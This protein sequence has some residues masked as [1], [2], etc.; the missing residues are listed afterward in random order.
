MATKS[1]GRVSIRVLPDSTKFRSDLR[2]TLDRIEKFMTVKIKVIP[3]L[4]KDQLLKIKQEIEKLKIKITPTIDLKV[5]AEDIARIK[6]QIE[7]MKP[8][9]TISL[10]TARA[11]A[12]MANLTRDRIVNIIP[13]I[14]RAAMAS[15][16]ARLGALAG[17][18]VL[19]D[20]FEEA[21]DFLR[22]VDR[23]AVSLGTLSTGIMTLAGAAGALVSNLL[24]LG[25]NILD[26][27]GIVSV[28]PAFGVGMG[29]A[30]G[31]IIAVMQ[32]AG[33][34]LGDLKPAFED[35]QKA[36]SES[37]WAKAEKPI[38]QLVDALLPQLKES[39]VGVS[40]ALGD[41][42]KDSAD[43]FRKNVT[44][45]RMRGM[46]LKLEEAIRVAGDAMDPMISAFTTLGEHGS[47]YFKRF[48]EWIVQLSEDFDA[49]I[50][51][52][53]TDGSLKRWTEQAIQAFKDLGSAI[54]GT[55]RFFEQLGKAAAEGGGADLK[56]FAD[57]MHGMADAM[58]DPRFQR[59]MATYFESF[60]ALMGG[61]MEGLERMGPGLESFAMPFRV[62]MGSV[63]DILQDILGYLGD[64]IG[65]PAFQ[66]GF[67]A[68][69]DGISDGIRGL[70]PAIDD[71]AIG[72]GGMFDMLGQIAEQ[73]GL[74]VGFLMDKWGP[75]FDVAGKAI[76]RLIE[77]LGETVRNIVEEL[78]PAFNTLT[79]EV[80][81]SLVSFIENHL[82]PTIDDLVDQLGPEFKD[83]IDN[84]A[85]FLDT[86]LIP[87]LESLMSFIR[88]NKEEIGG[89]LSMLNDIASWNID[90]NNAGA[91]RITPD[92]DRREKWTVRLDAQH[93]YIRD[94][95]KEAWRLA[96]EW[97][98]NTL[99]PSWQ[100][101][102]AK[103]TGESE[104]HPI[105]QWFVDMW[106]GVVAWWDGTLVPNWNQMW[107]DFMNPD[108]E[109]GGLNAWLM[110]VLD[111]LWVGLGE[112]WN[113]TVV[114]GWNQFW[115]DFFNPGLEAG[116]GTLWPWLLEQLGLMWESAVEWWDTTVVAGWN[117]F[118]TDFFNPADTGQ[119]GQLNEWIMGILD[120]MWTAVG[121][122]WET[123]VVAGWNQFWADLFGPHTTAGTD[124]VN[125]A[126]NTGTLGWGA[127][128][129][130][131]FGIT[132][133]TWDTFWAGL[134]ETLGIKWGDYDGT[135][136]SWA[137]TIGDTIWGF[138]T[139][140][141]TDWGAKWGEMG[142]TVKTKW[143]EYSSTVGTKASEI[144]TSVQQFLADTGS[145]WSTNWNNIKTTLSNAWT[146][147]T[148][149]TNNKTGTMG[150]AIR[151]F[152][153]TAYSNMSSSFGQ[154]YQTS[155]SNMQNMQRAVQQG[156]N[157]AVT[158]IQGLPGRAAGAL[159]SAG[160]T[161]YSSGASLIQGFIN[162]M[163]SMI[164][165]AAST[166]S[167]ILA[168]I[169]NFFP[170]SP[171]KEG[172]FSGKGWTLYSGRALME[173]FAEGMTGRMSQVRSAAEKAVGAAS[174][175]TDMEFPDVGENGI[176]VDRREVSVHTYNP[177]AEPTSRT[178][179]K[180]SSE[181]RMSGAL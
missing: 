48:A 5:D 117:Q 180:A 136:S 10:N 115:H 158:W 21:G 124:G 108:T 55:Y 28:L 7:R 171:A 4:D 114:P 105:D 85:K 70:E 19:K 166:A 96:Q 16:A 121:E 162:G 111:G 63:G 43:A 33:D 98:N 103:L 32:D 128:L 116:S 8:E 90:F 93:E 2:K 47:D 161:L 175:F 100:G 163:W 87:A 157:D 3:V 68:F 53:H 167:S 61:L 149:D 127:T 51:K 138:L 148:G 76:E 99:V 12:R 112:W 110:E 137:G 132:T 82:L 126:I 20:I 38:R 153:Q 69:F 102:W 86:T 78:T 165:T 144:Q 176:T 54:S 37:Y 18:G 89:F 164:N 173:G 80:I 178:I 104:L 41:F 71:F 15:V 181:L 45:E 31:A 95:M 101:L 152:G 1:A 79:K 168:T 139:G 29:I 143:G 94:S 179:E 109:G 130:N 141:N 154:I 27:V 35:M 118:W 107:D 49:F 44:P 88:D 62:A 17:L 129:A 75:G 73:L 155:Q 46:M 24:T 50:Q 120:G 151:S 40:D 84:V 133:P 145:N 147:M 13:R 125:E 142:T 135:V 156:I 52:A 6:E 83:A 39:M 14:S 9:V 42:T 36:M 159:S 11:A 23:Y 30:I 172:P 169:R 150:G 134:G 57:A 97:W 122:W 131:W 72:L 106:D 58:S 56:D 65:H 140:Q 74:T 119:G 64:I 113:G 34:V 22:N 59:S 174:I 91:D 77:P 160:S 26:I 146:N 25:G 81:P 66:E 92:M 170:S 60:H 67:M 177:V 123:T